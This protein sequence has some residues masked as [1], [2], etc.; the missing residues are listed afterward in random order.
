MSVAYEASAKYTISRNK[1]MVVPLY[2]MAS[3]AYY[4]EDDPIFS[5]SYYDEL[6]KTMLANYDTIK[7]HHKHLISI[8]DLEAGS[9]LGTYPGIVKGALHH[10]RYKIEGRK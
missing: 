10:W 8:D 9:Y 1:H 2:L 7:H 4:E 5:D 3:Y 6:A